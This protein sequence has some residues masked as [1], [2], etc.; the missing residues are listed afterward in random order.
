MKNDKAIGLDGIPAE[1][2]KSLGEEG[3]GRRR[4]QKNGEKALLC[5]SIKRRV[6][7]RVVQITEE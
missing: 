3:L 7:S 6:T 5:L 2:L 1:V 4:Y